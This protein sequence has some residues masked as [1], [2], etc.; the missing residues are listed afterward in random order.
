MAGE[1]CQLPNPNGSHWGCKLASHHGG[2]CD[3][4]T[5]PLKAVPYV[6]QERELVADDAEKSAPDMEALQRQALEN[7]CP[8]QRAPGKM[9]FRRLEQMSEYLMSRKVGMLAGM[10][11]Y[12]FNCEKLPVHFHVDV[13][14]FTPN[15]LTP[16]QR[17]AV[18]AGLEQVL[19]GLKKQQS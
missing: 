4:G 1:F 14:T 8:G 18:I 2:E 13:N 3:F 11:V 7:G 15:G 19:E 5:P 12:T 6:G 17:G 10:A 9:V 16:E